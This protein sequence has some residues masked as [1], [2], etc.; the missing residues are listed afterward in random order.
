MLL[1]SCALVSKLFPLEPRPE[2]PDWPLELS[3]AAVQ[4][5]T[6]RTLAGG[7]A[8]A[9]YLRLERAD[10]AGLGGL[11]PDG[12]VR[13]PDDGGTGEDGGWT[14]GDVEMARCFLNPATYEVWVDLDSATRRW[15]VVVSPI[16]DCAMDTFGGGGLY[17]IDADTFEIL[18]LKRFE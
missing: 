17:E 13:E 6:L 3:D 4:L 10:F 9:D 8:L 11:A 16:A 7:I 15:R 5:P 1:A 14:A 18:S 12:G 2:S